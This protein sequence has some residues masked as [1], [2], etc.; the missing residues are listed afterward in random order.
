MTKTHWTVAAAAVIA[1]TLG[2]AALAQNRAATR[3]AAVRPAACTMSYGT[4]TGTDG[5]SISVATLTCPRPAQQVASR[6]SL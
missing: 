4:E 5:R 1:A 2:T 6:A 3:T